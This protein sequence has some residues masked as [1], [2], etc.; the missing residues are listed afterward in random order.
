MT[1]LSEPLKIPKHML[2]T[3]AANTR[4]PIMQSSIPSLA[5]N[6]RALRRNHDEALDP[7]AHRHVYAA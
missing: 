2:E 7:D 4:R 6:D 1:L 3:K 5:L